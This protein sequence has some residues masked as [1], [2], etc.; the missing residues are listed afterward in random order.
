M[1]FHNA[2]NG[3]KIPLKGTSDAAICSCLNSAARMLVGKTKVL[4]RQR[5]PMVFD[6]YSWVALQGALNHMMI[7]IPYWLRYAHLVPISSNARA[8]H[9]VQRGTACITLSMS[10]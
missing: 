5:L 6:L 8:M 7:T 10:L 9:I 1:S 4:R 2:V 3:T